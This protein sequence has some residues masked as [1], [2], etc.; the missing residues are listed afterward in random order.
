MSSP[1]VLKSENPDGTNIYNN[2]PGESQVKGDLFDDTP[3]L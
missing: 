2:V 3:T 1:K